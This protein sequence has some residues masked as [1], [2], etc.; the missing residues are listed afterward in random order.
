MHYII[1]YLYSKL[2]STLWYLIIQK[3]KS[4]LEPTKIRIILCT[5]V[6][7]IPW[8]F[9]LWIIA[10]QLDKILSILCTYEWIN[11][12]NLGVVERALYNL[13][14]LYHF[15]TTNEIANEKKKSDIVYHVSTNEWIH[16]E[17]QSEY[18][19]LC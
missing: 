10:L 7:Y 12:Y 5:F 18:T 2:Y 13:G 15:T 17:L 9:F 6:I 19:N 4:I 3:L 8:R 16:E 14:Y 1:Q 11:K